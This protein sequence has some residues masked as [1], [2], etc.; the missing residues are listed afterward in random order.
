M[1]NI[2]QFKD[3][4]IKAGLVHSEA[5]IYLALLESGLSRATDLARLSGIQRSNVY[6][7]LD[8]LKKKG[9]VSQFIKEDGV[10]YFTPERPE[11]I[12]GSLEKKKQ[13]LDKIVQGYKQLL[14]SIKELG[15]KYTMI[16]SNVR[17]YDSVDGINQFY[18][19]VFSSGKFMAFV[20]ID[21]VTRYYPDYTWGLIQRGKKGK[22]EARELLVD[23]PTARKYKKEIVNPNHEAKLLPKKYSF[24]ADIVLYEEKTALISYK[25]N[26]SA[27]SIEDTM[28]NKAQTALF[29]SLWEKTK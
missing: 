22:I 29:E 10:R 8:N 19:E 11:R 24:A 15:K 18:E 20:D 6:Y 9:L 27:F 14:P 3:Q 13:E 12:I 2:D 21:S 28:I 1:P 25:K 26:I 5:K 23:S 17:F 16:H 4:L 7:F